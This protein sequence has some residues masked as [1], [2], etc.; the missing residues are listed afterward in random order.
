ML[1]RARMP[2]I[3][4]VVLGGLLAA[5]PD[6]HAQCVLSYVWTCSEDDSVLRRVALDGLA[7]E[8]TITIALPGTP[9]T[10]ITGI[11]ID[12]LTETFY[13]LAYFGPGSSPF[14]LQY[15]PNVGVAQ[16]LGN[17]FVDF[18]ALQF[19]PTGELRAISAD[20]AAIVSTFCDL[21]LLSGAPTDICSFGNGDAGEAIAYEPISGQ[22]FHASGATNVVFEEQDLVMGADPCDVLP[23]DVAT[24]PLAGTEVSGLT[25]WPEE[26]AFLWSQVGPSSA[27]Y[28]VTA[29]G[30]VTSLGNLGHSVSDMAVVEIATPCPPPNE[31]ERGDTN[32]DGSINIADAVFTLSV[33]FPQP[34]S[35]PQH[36]CDDAAD[37]NDD[38]SINIADAVSI[39]S[40]LFPQPGM[41]PTFPDPTGACGQDPTGDALSCLQSI[42]P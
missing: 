37:A 36:P 22:V 20:T 7:I 8:E 26:D 6:T 10:G 18:V 19:L 42:C 34:G 12:P 17:T 21:D 5:T 2:L 35:T 4:F 28:L 30:T 31:F 1:D 27:L 16:V 32:D 3:L 29:T 40:V 23:I 24:T 39:L 11:S 13:L 38:G 15:D 9:I 41:T 14:L 25:Y 33:L